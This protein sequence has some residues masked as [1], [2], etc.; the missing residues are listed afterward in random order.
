VSCAAR[1]AGFHQHDVNCCGTDEAYGDAYDYL[2]KIDVLKPQKLAN[3]KNIMLIPR[4]DE[5]QWSI[6]ISDNQKK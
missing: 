2:K 1:S 6:Y 4:L 5:R 3:N